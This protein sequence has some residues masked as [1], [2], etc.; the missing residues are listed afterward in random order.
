MGTVF[1]TSLHTLIEGARLGGVDFQALCRRCE[2]SGADLRSAD[3]AGGQP[4]GGRPLGRY[5]V[6]IQP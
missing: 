1:K 5:P 6:R 3:L 2:R 4:L